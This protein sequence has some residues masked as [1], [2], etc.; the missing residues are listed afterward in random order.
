MWEVEVLDAMDRNFMSRREKGKEHMRT[1]LLVNK[2]H[3]AYSS[4]ELFCLGNYALV[5]KFTCA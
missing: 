4:I 2:L 5:S 1:D 3:S